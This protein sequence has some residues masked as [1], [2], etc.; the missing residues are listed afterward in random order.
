MENIEVKADR[1]SEIA[2][3]SKKAFIFGI[4][5]DV[6]CWT[7]LGGIIFG[8]L[9]MKNGKLGLTMCKEDGARK[10]V[11]A[12]IGRILGIVGLAVGIFFI[13]YWAIIIIAALVAGVAAAAY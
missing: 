3:V 4:L 2:S 8:I 1:S 7:V 10:N 6:L 9:A 5:A 11:F 13:V 12:L